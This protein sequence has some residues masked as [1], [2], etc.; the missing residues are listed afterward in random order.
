MIPC[1]DGWQDPYP[2]NRYL[3]PRDAFDIDEETYPRFWIT[4]DAWGSVF[5]DRTTGRVRE[6]EFWHVVRV[7]PYTLRERLAQLLR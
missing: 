2:I 6:K 4:D 7:R 5:F 1:G 3:A